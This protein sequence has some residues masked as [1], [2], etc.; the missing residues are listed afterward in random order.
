LCSNQQRQRRRQNRQCPRFHDLF[1]DG[2][3]AR[4]FTVRM[5]YEV[6][7]SQ[8]RTL[9]TSSDPKG[10]RGGHHQPEEHLSILAGCRLAT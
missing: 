10:F 6:S 8:N 9:A 2:L 1:P 7:L 5:R 4:D 3:V